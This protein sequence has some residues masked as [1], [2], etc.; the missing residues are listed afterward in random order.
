MA[1]LSRVGIARV[2]RAWC[3]RGDDAWTTTADGRAPG[4]ASRAVTRQIDMHVMLPANMPEHTPVVMRYDISDPYAVRAQFPATPGP[5]VS[6]VFARD[7]LSQ[8]LMAPTGDG[9]MRIWPTESGGVGLRI[10]LKSPH[11]EGLVQA[12]TA[13]VD[14]FLRQ[15]YS[16][17]PPGREGDY[18]DVDGALRQ[19]LVT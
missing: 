14:E 4:F 8:G 1:K 9:D 18:V 12:A 13:D 15:S 11:G 2:L 7:L 16:L 3:G 10:S 19:L 17:C 5:P 6:W